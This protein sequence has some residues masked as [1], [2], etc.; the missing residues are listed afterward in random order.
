MCKCVHPNIQLRTL[1]VT[2]CKVQE[3]HDHVYL[4][5]LYLYEKRQSKQIAL[6]DADRSKFRNF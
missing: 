2:F 6:P 5:G 4:V 3:Q 1:K